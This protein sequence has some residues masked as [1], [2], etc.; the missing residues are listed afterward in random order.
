MRTPERSPVLNRKLSY[1]DLSLLV[2]PD[3]FE[4]ILASRKEMAVFQYPITL[5]YFVVAR[6]K[7]SNP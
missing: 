4:K 7:M 1:D 3:P 5:S 6:L 2:R